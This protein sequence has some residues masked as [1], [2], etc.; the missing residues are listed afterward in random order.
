MRALRSMAALVR[1][2]R[3]LAHRSDDLRR[4]GLAAALMVLLAGGCR[5]RG[6]PPLAHEAYVAQASSLPGGS[7]VQPALLRGAHS[8]TRQA[9]SAALQGMAAREP[10]LDTRLLSATIGGR[11]RRDSRV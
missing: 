3:A 10:K 9:S 11:K 1:D 8:A 2:S 4:R 5:G 6:Q 7:A